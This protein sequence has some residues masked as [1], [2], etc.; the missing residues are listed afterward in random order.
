MS[1]FKNDKMYIN[2]S[3]FFNDEHIDQIVQIAQRVIKI[4]KPLS[5][6]KERWLLNRD[7]MM[8]HKRC[9]PEQVLSDMFKHIESIPLSSFSAL[10]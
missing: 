1:E 5:E 4:D 8:L 7:L 10:A 6:I 2:Q 9:I 3:H